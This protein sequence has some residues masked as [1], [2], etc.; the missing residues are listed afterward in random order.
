MPVQE[1]KLHS[2]SEDLY[3]MT[4]FFYYNFFFK[5]MTAS[6]VMIVLTH[7]LFENY[8]I[9]PPKKLKG[10]THQKDKCMSIRAIYAIT[11]TLGPVIPSFSWKI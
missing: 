5:G 1:L 8:K 9:Y 11:L 3:F 4:F 10:I 7:H 2:L 6:Q